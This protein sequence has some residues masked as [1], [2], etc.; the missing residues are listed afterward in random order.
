MTQWV[1]DMKHNI[2][3]RKAKLQEV[4]QQLPPSSVQKILLT[5][6]VLLALPVSL[7]LLQ[8]RTELALKAQEQLVRLYISPAQTQNPSEIFMRVMA[9]AQSN[10]V[11][12]SRVVLTF[13]PGV[14]ALS[15]EVQTSTLFKTVV[16]KTS[17]Q[18][19]NT[20]GRV[21]I[22]LGL[23][24]GNR[25]TPPTALFEL[26][27]LT[28]AS[29]TTQPNVATYLNFD[30]S[31]MQIVD[32]QTTS[33]NFSGENATIVLNPIATGTLTGIV[34]DEI[35]AEPISGASMTIKVAGSKGK[36]GLVTTA[37]SD[38][39]GVYMLS[40]DSGSYDVEANAQGYDAVK[41]ST[42]ITEQTTTTINFILP[43][44]S[45]GGGKGPKPR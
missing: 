21:T 37:T 18:E 43:P 45:K 23:D 27:E 42:T 5:T 30:A 40:L 25:T 19:A 15:Q 3:E 1:Q 22:V 26:L 34:T 36:S 9:D 4:K 44:K 31:D 8:R 32:M 2:S 24:P 41:Q 11:T 6:I 14:L 20:T 17:M 10:Q 28:L 7:I 33:L 13:D 12:F 29:K 16:Q 35:T 38:A 39:S